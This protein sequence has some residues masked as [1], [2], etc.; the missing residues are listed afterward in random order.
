MDEHEN[1]ALPTDTMLPEAPATYSDE[2][3]LEGIQIVG[4]R[5][6]LFGAIA[7]AQKAFEPIEKNREVTVRP[8]EKAPYSFKY[9]THDVVLEATRPALNREGL[10]LLSLTATGR[11][12]DDLLH[13][14]LTHE[15][16]A[17]IAMTVNLGRSNSPQ[18][19]GS[20]LTYARRYADSA[21]LGVSAEFDDDGNERQGATVESSRDT[22][23]PKQAPPIS[24]PKG[25]ELELEPSKLQAFQSLIKVELERLDLKSG[26]K[27]SI[28]CQEV[29]KTKLDRLTEESAKLFLEHLRGMQSPQK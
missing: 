10:A 18:E 2:L 12:G 16:G 1:T 24:A 23:Q 20:G 7:R 26:P 3:K 11:N 27:A 22:R 15:S 8:R 6:T 4:D 29:T 17:A 14:L 9:A 13:S 19:Y 25:R 5:A 28:L 21:L